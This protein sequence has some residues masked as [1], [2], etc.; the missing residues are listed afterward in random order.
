MEELA[1]ILFVGILMS[2]TKPPLR[3]ALF[4][5]ESTGK[6]HLAEALAQKYAEP[7]VSEYVREF[8]ELRQGKIESGDLGEIAVGQ[9]RSE[10]AAASL[11]RKVVFCDTELLTNVLWADL[12][13]PGCCPP[14]VRL[15]ADQRCRHY[16]VY[17]LCLTDLPFFPDPQRVF[18]D[19]A[20]RIACMQRWRATLLERGLPTVEI[21]GSGSERLERACAV[22]DSLLKSAE[23]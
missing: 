6:T 12:L 3:I 4:G 11:A 7:W 1:E 20:D 2:S 17:L 22:V 19:E 9:I 16:A 18:S 10:E 21:F 13:F 8:W 23:L 15:E 5:P 14:W